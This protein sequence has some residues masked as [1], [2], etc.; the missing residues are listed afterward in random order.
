[1]P[2]QPSRTDVAH[3]AEDEQVAGQHAGRARHV[4]RLAGDES[5]AQ[6]L[7]AAAA[8]PG[9]N[10]VLR[11]RFSD[12]RPRDGTRARCEIDETVAIR[13]HRRRAPALDLACGDGGIELPVEGCPRAAPIVEWMRCRA[14]ASTPC[15]RL[16]P[17]ASAR[18]AAVPS[19]NVMARRVSKI[20]TPALPHLGR[21]LRQDS[22]FKQRG[23]SA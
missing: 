11:I 15:G 8:V 12:Q 1:M 9:G 7:P 23:V 2:R 14:R 6:S 4:L 10:G 20:S 16:T 13:C 21:E 19:E 17:P 3:V 18:H 5:P 22:A